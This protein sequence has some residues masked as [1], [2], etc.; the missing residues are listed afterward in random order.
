MKSSILYV[1]MKFSRGRFLCAAL[2]T[3]GAILVISLLIAGWLEITFFPLSENHVRDTL[4]GVSGAVVPL[5][6]LFR[7]LSKKAGNRA[8]DRSLKKTALEIREL[9]GHAS[10]SDIFFISLLAGVS[11][12]FLFRGVIQ[13]KLGIFFASVLFGLLHCITPVYAVLAM[14]M[15]FYLGLFFLISESLL[16]PVVVHAVYDLG[17]LIYLRYFMRA[18]GNG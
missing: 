9:F 5:I 1:D 11:E 6:L 7:A 14:L 4:I 18:E 12:E 13:A 3:E 16:V 10:L 17:A 2:V 15:G 8:F